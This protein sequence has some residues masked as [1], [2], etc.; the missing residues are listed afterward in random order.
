[1]ASTM[2][3]LPSSCDMSV[4]NCFWIL[5]RNVS[6][7]WWNNFRHLFELS[8][9]GNVFHILLWFV[10]FHLETNVN[11]LIAGRNLVK[12][13]HAIFP[14]MLRPTQRKTN[15]HS[16][17]QPFTIDYLWMDN[18]KTNA[19]IRLL[20]AA[21]WIGESQLN[22]SLPATRLQDRVFLLL[23]YRF[24]CADLFLWVT[25]GDRNCIWTDPF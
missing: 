6:A 14:F 24:N 11:L 8:F 17:F 23:C 18:N 4:E 1:M 22:T 20:R 19:N 21:T 15:P 2:L 13:D 7:D 3:S 12:M 9:R 25:P 10:V 16:Y 5:S